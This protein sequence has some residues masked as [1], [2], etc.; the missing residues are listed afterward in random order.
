MGL[1]KPSK[2]CIRYFIFFQ[3]LQLN[4]AVTA[5]DAILLQPVLSW[6]LSFVVTMALR[7]RLTQS[8][9]L[10]FGLPLLLLPD[11]T[12]SRVFRP[13]YSLYLLFTCPHH[14]SLDFLHLSVMFSAFYLSLMS[15]LLTWSISVWPHADLHIFISV[16]SSF[17]TWELVIGT[18]SI[19]ICVLCNK[20][21]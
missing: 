20:G 1:I 21:Q 15:L 10:C 11:G 3:P 9:H 12:I 14:L 8:I 16:T 4:C 6:T 17:L 7:S 5:A 19:R 18:V 13:T 2:A